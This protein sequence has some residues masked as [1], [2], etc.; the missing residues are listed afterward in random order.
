V[1]QDMYG[2]DYAALRADLVVNTACEHIADLR[3]WLALLP[4]GTKV[5][6]QSNDYFSEPSHISCVE[7]VGA[8]ER[9][10]GLSE[11]RFSGSLQ[12]K[13][14]TRFMLIGAV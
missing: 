6:L 12:Q 4:R 13:K 14:Y 8:F 7:N 9:L 3:G 1:T 5:L 11:L 10:A 2:I